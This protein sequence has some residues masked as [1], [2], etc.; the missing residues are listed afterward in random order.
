[1]S[2][3]LENLTTEPNEEPKDQVIYMIDTSE[4]E[5]IGKLQLDELQVQ[6]EI[7]THEQERIETL[8]SICICILVILGA[9]L[10]SIVFRHLRK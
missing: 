1:M 2:D 9:V 4:L 5:R 7:L 8:H 10:G 6:T 3:E